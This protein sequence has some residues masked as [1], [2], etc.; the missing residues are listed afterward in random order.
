MGVCRT[1]MLDVMAPEAHQNDHCYVYM[2][3]ADL[4][5]IDYTRIQ[6]GGQLHVDLKKHKTVKIGGWTL[7]QGR[8]LAWDNT[9]L[10]FKQ[11]FFD[12]CVQHPVIM[13]PFNLLVGTITVEWKYASWDPGAQSAVRL[14]G[15]TLMLVL[16][17]GS[18]DSHHMVCVVH[19]AK[20]LARG[21]PVA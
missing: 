17:A 20:R 14:S 11:V 10:I 13:E 9:A 3:A 2:S 18:S 6:H 4:L 1:L 15:T 21:V 7:A 12:F 8:A 19:Y 5:L 16:S